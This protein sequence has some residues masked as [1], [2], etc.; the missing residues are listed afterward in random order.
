M[1]ETSSLGA[2]MIREHKVRELTLSWVAMRTLQRKLEFEGETMTDSTD[3]VDWYDGYMDD[4]DEPKRKRKPRGEASNRLFLRSLYGGIHMASDARVKVKIEF[5]ATIEADYDGAG[6][7]TITAWG[8]DNGKKETLLQI[9]VPREEDLGRPQYW[10]SVSWGGL[11][12]RKLFAKVMTRE[13]ELKK[14]K[15]SAPVPVKK[16]VRRLS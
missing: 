9:H 6:G 5:P 13:G 7:Y 4:A 2:I 3:D 14:A 1:H 15:S 11:L 10:N 12:L 16:P 8:A